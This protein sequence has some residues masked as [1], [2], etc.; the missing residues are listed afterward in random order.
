[1][2]RAHSA[3]LL[4]TTGCS[5]TS[6]S[7]KV[8]ALTRAAEYRSLPFNG[9]QGG[10]APGRLGKERRVVRI[11][12]LLPSATEIVCGLGLEDQLVGVTH[13]CDYPPWCVGSRR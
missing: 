4:A 13:E 7:V 2:H 3:H 1:M 12:S 10:R 6:S 11:V 9:D 5:D 8:F